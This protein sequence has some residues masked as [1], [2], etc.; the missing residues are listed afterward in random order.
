MAGQLKNISGLFKNTRT[1]AIL[2]VTIGLIIFGVI[3]GVVS[4]RKRMAVPAGTALQGSPNI[5][6]VPGGFEKP[7]TEEYVK[8]QTQQNVEQA[9][10]AHK[11]GTTAI[12]TIVSSAPIT[13]G[14]QGGQ[15]STIGGTSGQALPANYLLKGPA[16]SEG[17]PVYNSQG[18]MTGLAYGKGPN[19]EVCVMNCTTT[20]KVSPDG[21]I[22]DAKGN[23]IGKVAASALGNPVYDKDGR[24]IGYA[25]SDGKV[26]DAKG[27]VVGSIGSDGV[28]RDNAGR[29]GKGALGT[30]VYDANGRL[31]GYADPNGVVKGLNGNILGKVDGDGVARDANGRPIG[32]AAASA[33][34]TPVY[35]AQGRLVGYAGPDGKVRDANGN[36]IG[37]VGADG[38][39]R[40]SSGKVI[41]KAVGPLPSAGGSAQGT[42]VYDAQGK[43]I[44]YASPDGKVRDA[45]GKVIG[46]VGP[47][48]TVRDARGRVI[49]KTAAPTGGAAAATK[50]TPVY[51]S[52]GRL[53]GYASPDGTVRDANGKVV[54]NLAADGT[55]RDANGNIIG[56]VATP[57]GRTPAGLP[58]G[59]AGAPPG[60][61]PGGGAPGGIAAATIGGPAGIGPTE[62][63]QLQALRQRQ[64]QQIEQQ[65]NQQNVQQAT[66]N[67]TTQQGQLFAS[68][69]AASSQQYVE[70]QK[71]AAEKEGGKTTTVTEVGGAP[72]TATTIQTT[73]AGGG[74]R[75]E[76]FLKAG[77]IL[78]AVL[79]T[80]VNSDEPG[81][82]MATIVGNRL[83][84]G[85]LLGTLVNQ[86]QKV[87]LT[88]NVLTLPNVPSS[89][90]L[91]AVAI[92][93]NTA[94][95]A[96][97]S[98]TDNHYLL[99]Y[100]S[101]FAAA[102]LQG[103]GQA[104]Q[105]SGAVVVSNG[106]NT[107]TNMPTL[108]PK[109]Q[110]LAALGTVGQVWGEAIRPL[111]NTPPTVKVF[112]CTPLGILILSDVAPPV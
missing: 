84:G 43:L 15:F 92:D 62:A 29:A 47:D 42:P 5:Q 18:L 103:Y 38:V 27:N 23:V 9:R 112:S 99:R 80:A 22:R 17:I 63:E 58:P 101:M 35:D 104:V 33:L 94:R 79:N 24:L 49:G 110:A 102:F 75:S 64:Q 13:G 71:E 70:G 56:S 96:L 59:V 73:T 88:F 106:L 81:P 68:W 39:A 72:G 21:L 6:S 61:A 40:D 32:K 19:G 109:G 1:R 87:M 28:F 82:V 97:S 74:P 20:G 60:A 51:D 34:G 41:G 52:Q 44:G 12:P 93:P 16:D 37:T 48:G 111:F 31:I 105:Q 78:F 3:I 107:V 11:E 90:S 46:T 8:L 7:E 83:K 26:R 57:A 85:K 36:E 108:S 100:G 86:G 67:M 50:G 91:N 4:L 69:T 76:P 65:Q 66:A 10:R 54:G 25:G 14:W 98:D 95:T 53:I 45:S 30:P 2:I 55:L 77:T 89:I